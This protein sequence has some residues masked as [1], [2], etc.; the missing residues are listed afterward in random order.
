M[1]SPASTGSAGMGK[2]ENIGSAAVAGAQAGAQ[3]KQTIATTA[4]TEEQER[5]TAAEA[6]IAEKNIPKATIE[7]DVMSGVGSAYDAAKKT[8]PN[9]YNT[10]KPSAVLPGPAERKLNQQKNKEW[11]QKKLRDANDWLEKKEKAAK[12]PSYKNTEKYRAYKERNKRRTKTKK[13]SR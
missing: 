11:L 8:A 2:M 5:K 13:R 7:E 3:V 4:L 12:K 1:T 9:L 10:L 6:T